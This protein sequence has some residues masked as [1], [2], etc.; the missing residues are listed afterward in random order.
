MK[1]IRNI[2]LWAFLAITI[3]S[4]FGQV[5]MVASVNV[6]PPLSIG[7]TFTYTLEAQSSGTEY[8]AVRVRINYDP[9]LLQVNSFTNGDLFDF[10]PVQNT[11]TPGLVHY[12][13]G[14]LGNIQTGNGTI[15]SV[16]FQVLNAD[17][18]IIISND[19]NA[20]NG[21]FVSDPDGDNVLGTTNDVVLETLSVN[22]KWHAQLKVYPNPADKDLFIQLSEPSKVSHVNLYSLEGKLVKTY[23]QLDVEESQIHLK[24]QDLQSAFYL[25]KIISHSD[26]QA[27][28]KISVSH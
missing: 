19:T 23:D 8:T 27:T 17:E 5:D 7:Q 22:A 10:V 28:F 16:E 6:T 21:A 12:E 18:S 15:F 1:K 24:L 26:E 20:S 11:D 3:Q 14:S 13:G 25:V 4:G 9:S 2:I